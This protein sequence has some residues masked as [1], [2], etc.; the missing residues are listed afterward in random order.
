MRAVVRM[1]A[2]LT[3][4]GAATVGGVGFIHPDTTAAE[5][6]LP[7]NTAAVPNAQGEFIVHPDASATEYGVVPAA[8]ATEYGIVRPAAS[9]TEYG[10]LHTDASATEYGLLL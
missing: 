6:A 2:G 4:L 1:V 5:Y 3:V 7:A 8:S 10:L 9:A